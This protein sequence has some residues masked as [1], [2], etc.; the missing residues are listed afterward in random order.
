MS[1]DIEMRTERGSY[2]MI[3]PSART[4]TAGDLSAVFLPGLGMLGASLRHRGEEL[5]GLVDDIEAFAVAGRSCGIP[6]L[7]PWANR[8]DGLRY[9]AAGHEVVLDHTSSL[10]HFIEDGLPIHG[11]PWSRLSWQVT[12]EDT[13]TLKAQLEWT[14]DNLLAVFP[15]PHRLEMAVALDPNNLTIETTLVAGADGPVPV[16]FGFHPYL[17][18]P[19]LPRA[20]WQIQVPAMQS[21]LLDTRHLPTGEETPF[22]GLDTNLDDLDFDDGFAVL[23]ERSSFSITGGG[24][25]IALEFLEGYRYAQVFAPSGKDYLALEPM[26]APANALVTG[27]G[28]R[29]VEPGGMFHTAFRIGVDLLL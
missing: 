4:L 9:Q 7:H 18:L 17:R 27:R 3:N 13:T 24:R 6:L 5:L 26:T 8:L 12:G 15:F 28:L 16:S 11:V 1:Q 22:A 21:L 2:I 25:R 14:S 10:L 19:G 23:E 29:F 20:E